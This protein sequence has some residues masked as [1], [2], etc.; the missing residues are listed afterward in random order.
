MP[1]TIQQALAKVK[2]IEQGRMKRA[3]EELDYE[4]ACFKLGDTALKAVRSGRESICPEL[5]SFD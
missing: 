5:D 3:S 2:Q 1:L 4:D